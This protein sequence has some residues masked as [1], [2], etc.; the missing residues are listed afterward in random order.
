MSNLVK[1]RK[2]L[3]IKLA[4]KSAKVFKGVLNYNSISIKPDDFPGFIPKIIKKEGN[5]VK[6]GDIVV[7]DKYRPEIALTSP[8]SG[9]VA[10]IIRGEKRKILEIIIEN[11]HKDDLISFDVLENEDSVDK[12]KDVFL[13]SGVWSLIKQRPYGIIA[14]PNDTPRDIFITFFDS[15]PLAPDYDFILEDRIP[16][17]NLAIEKISKFTNGKVYLCFKNGSILNDKIEKTNNSEIYFFEGPHPS[18]LPGTHINKIKPINKG[19]IVWTLNATDLLIIGK[20]IKTGIYNPERVFALAGS[21]VKS[22]GY[23]KAVSGANISELINS[24]NISSENY[25]V[26]SGNVLTGRNVTQRPYL[27]YFDNLVCVIPEGN[28][29]EFLGWLKPGIDKFSSSRTFLSKLFPKKEYIIDTNYHGGRRAYV[30]TGQYEKV[31]PIDIYPQILIKAILAEDIERIEQLGI[32]EVIEED[33]AL[34]EYVC[35]SKIEVQ[36]ILRKGLD[37][38]RKEFA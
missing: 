33:L 10:S 25:R 21:E 16:Y 15:S 23:Y 13:K 6:I 19:E 34:C 38:I 4:G 3:D 2:G 22:S 12:I 32:Y 29:Y 14:N 20:F 17:L 7:I 35:T 24:E 8:V 27:G 28:K 36:E 18:G 1:I 9:K 37:L 5:N 26:I 30:V 31:C 11:D